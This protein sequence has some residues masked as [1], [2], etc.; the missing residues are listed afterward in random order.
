MQAY[1][2]PYQLHFKSPVK[3]SRGEMAVKNGYYLYITRDGKTGVG[4]C[5]FIEGLSIDDLDTYPDALQQLCNAIEKADKSLLPDFK[6]YPSLKFAYE[7]A[8]LDWQ[9]G[10]RQILFESA[11]TRGEQHIPINGLIWMGSKDFM[12]NQIKQKLADGFRCIKI[13]VGAID[14][15]EEVQL[16]KYIRAQFPAE[17]IEIRLDANGAF[18]EADVFSKL[19]TLS[20]FTIHSIEQPVKQGQFELMTR[21]CRTSPIP[22]AL[23][24]EL[25]GITSVIHKA[26]LLNII[27]PQ[28]I[29]LKPSLIGGLS[30]CDEWIR[31]ARQLNINWWATSALESNIGLNA[32]AQWVFTKHPDMVQGLGTGSLYTNNIEGPLYI[33]E[34][35]LGFAPS[36]PFDL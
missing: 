15:D 6:K 29:I 14:F 8:L 11:F 35:E 27:Q 17:V 28:Y 1:F 31:I 34:G 19:Q 13:K 2:K 36:T 3:T 18:A 24:E 33:A 5:S 20:Q 21:V 26:E 12:F 7:T 30:S 22:V 4:E 23:D 9:M 16:I 10:G 32:I 25:I